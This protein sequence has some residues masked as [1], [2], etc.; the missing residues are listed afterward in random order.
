MTVRAF[1]NLEEYSS[2]FAMDKELGQLPPLND[3]GN[4]TCKH[5]QTFRHLKRN[6]RSI[7]LSYVVDSFMDL[8]R[9]I[10]RQMTDCCI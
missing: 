7:V 3:V 4:G 10:G 5:L 8:K 9:V 2:V 6:H 1:V